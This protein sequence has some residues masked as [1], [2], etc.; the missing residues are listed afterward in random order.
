MVVHTKGFTSPIAQFPQHLTVTSRDMC[1]LQAN[2]EIFTTASHL[3][4]FRK[5]WTCYAVQ[6]QNYVL[7]GKSAADGVGA[8]CKRSADAVVVVAEGDIDS[9]EYFV[10][11]RQQRCPNIPIFT[12]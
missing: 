5:R 11:T 9:L 10:G 12:I 6:E 1:T 8:T 3:H 2:F 7:Y 4:S